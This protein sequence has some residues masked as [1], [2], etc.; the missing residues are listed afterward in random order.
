MEHRHFP[1][2]RDIW[3]FWETGTVTAPSPNNLEYPW[4][5]FAA[6]IGST[7][8][9]PPSGLREEAP[10]DAR[11]A[12][13]PGR[14]GPRVETGLR[15]KIGS[16]EAKAAFDD[17]MQALLHWGCAARAGPNLDSVIRFVLTMRGDLPTFGRLYAQT[18]EDWRQLTRIINH[19]MDSVS[20][21]DL[22]QREVVLGVAGMVIRE[23]F[24]PAWEDDP[25]KVNVRTRFYLGLGTWA[26]SWAKP[27]E[28]RLGFIS[29]TLLDESRKYADDTAAPAVLDRALA[30]YRREVT[31]PMPRTSVS[32]R[33][34]YALNASMMWLT[35]S[36]G[37]IDLARFFYRFLEGA[38]SGDQQTP[39]TP[40]FSRETLWKFRRVEEHLTARLGAAW[41]QNPID[42]DL[43]ESLRS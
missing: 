21:P 35:V 10:L 23:L 12:E 14:H 28:V 4:M 11:T 24:D 19:N 29:S 30:A 6:D 40:A 22:T 1:A 36:V 17:A 32:R 25:W 33:E 43:C 15:T 18:F 26:L 16:P 41:P 8:T 5:S 13:L 38:L 9:E 2:L 31:G 34:R 37:R 42:Q 39:G 20:D 27:P 3:T 7:K